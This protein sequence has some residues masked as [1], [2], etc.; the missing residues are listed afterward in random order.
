MMPLLGYGISFYWLT[1]LELALFFVYK[2]LVLVFLSEANE[3][4][5]TSREVVT[6]VLAMVKCGWLLV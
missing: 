5:A 2:A 3:V 1:L 6:Y 4:L